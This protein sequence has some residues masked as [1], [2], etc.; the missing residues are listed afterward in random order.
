MVL[1]YKSQGMYIPEYKHTS[2]FIYFWRSKC[3]DWFRVIRLSSRHPHKTESTPFAAVS[4][5][6]PT[7]LVD[8]R[9]TLLAAS[10]IAQ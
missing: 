2:L 7:A 9:S 8:D 10:A 5:P 3:G 6:H 4:L 1:R